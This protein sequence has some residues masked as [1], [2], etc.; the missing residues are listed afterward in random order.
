MKNIYLLIIYIFGFFIFYNIL[1]FFNVDE[2][3]FYFINNNNNNDKNSNNNNKKTKPQKEG[4]ILTPPDATKPLKL[5]KQEIG[6]HAW[7]LLHSVAASY[8]IEP[9][10]EDKKQIEDFINGLA[11]SFPC[12]ICGKHFVKLLK[13]HPIKN[14]NREELVYYLCDIHNIVNKVL[15]KP[16][17]DCDKAFDIWGGDCG[18]NTE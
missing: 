9:T 5:T 15:D 14:N 11:Y 17:F 18:C 1:T 16:Y 3:L 13:E 2:K 12:K 7:S 6:R 10:D 8:P 4:D